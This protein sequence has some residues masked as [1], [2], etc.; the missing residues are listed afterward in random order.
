MLTKNNFFIVLYLISFYLSHD[1]LLAQNNRIL[2]QASLTNGD[3]SDKEITVD[4]KK[5]F[6]KGNDLISQ[7]KIELIFND[8]TSVF[9][10]ED[11]YKATTLDEKLATVKAGLSSF[12]YINLKENKSFYNNNGNPLFDDKEFLIY[13]NFDFDWKILTEEKTIDSFKVYKA[14]GMANKNGKRVN[15]IAWFAPEIPFKHGPYGIGNLPG[16]ILE[17]QLGP[18]H[19][20]AKEINLNYSKVAIELPTKGKQIH[21]EDF[22]KIQIERL[23]DFEKSVKF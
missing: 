12:I 5:I 22:Y 10:V 14:T 9:K 4:S 13:S 8:T 3:V 6:E 1:N 17:M 21:V 19:Y 11:S 2:Y 20:M 16:I 23:K 15:V 7:V 18:L